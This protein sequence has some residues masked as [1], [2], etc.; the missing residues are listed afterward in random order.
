VN[1]RINQRFWLL[2]RDREGRIMSWRVL[3]AF[4]VLV[5]AG[6]AMAGVALG[7]WLVGEA[8]GL[9][10]GPTT[11]T[12]IAPALVLDAAGRPLAGV[13]PQP[14][15]D[16]TLGQPSLSP[17]MDWQV[18]GVSLFESVLDPMV[19]LA[20]GDETFN[21]SDMLSRA[22]TGLAQGINDVAMV[23][24]T[25]GRPEGENAD[26]IADLIADRSSSQTSTQ[27]SSQTPMPATPS[28]TA[29]DW[30]EQL[31]KAIKACEN[32]GFFSRP[33][34]IE[35]ARNKFCEPNKAWGRDNLCPPRNSW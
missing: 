19:V 12:T 9:S 2:W 10:S 15:V 35:R 26:Q 18:D 3:I 30:P 7:N 34:C 27:T 11:N 28:P 4:L 33:N 5:M 1:D 14:L 32:V 17:V 13:P 6:A 22:G 31:S 8:P 24:V 23:D 21:V 16:G 25:E 29:A 20:K